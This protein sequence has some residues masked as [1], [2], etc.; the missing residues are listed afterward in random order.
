MSVPDS[1]VLLSSPSAI[2]QTSSLL[3]LLPGELRN[4]IYSF[5]AEPKIRSLR[6]N[7]RPN[8]GWKRSSG[9]YGNLRCVC[10]QVREEFAPIYAA[11][12]T[13][14][15]H[16]L[17]A[18]LYI[19]AF[20]PHLVES[21]KSPTIARGFL[22]DPTNTL[23]IATYFGMEFDARLLIRLCQQQSEIKV[24]F[25]DASACLD[26]AVELDEFF[27]SIS[28]GAFRPDMENTFH[29]IIIRCTLQ[30]SITVKFRSNAVFEKSASSVEESELRG[31]LVR[32]GAPAL[33][34]F[35]L[36]LG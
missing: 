35:S 30:P 7:P 5:C 13:I 29:S 22:F 32:M 36:R 19:K 11:N 25:L 34:S 33:T 23:E 14:R 31:E 15:I 3:L 27:A 17:T 6:R 10:R 20:Y 21:T 16:E 12:T 4:H 28:S 1:T 26:L 24:K 2:Q 8:N 9:R 18:D